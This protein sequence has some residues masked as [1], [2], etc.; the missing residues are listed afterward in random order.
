MTGER[1]GIREGRQYFSRLAIVTHPC[2]HLEDSSAQMRMLNIEERLHSSQFIRMLLQETRKPLSKLPTVALFPMAA[3]E[4]VAA[5]VL[6]VDRL[7]L[8][9]ERRF[10][11]LG[12]MGGESMLFLRLLARIQLFHEITVFPSFPVM[13]SCYKDLLHNA[14]VRPTIIREHLPP[15]LAHHLKLI[16]KT[17]FSKIARNKHRV[18]HLPAIPFKRVFKDFR[19]KIAPG[20][21]MAHMDIRHGGENQFRIS[22]GKHPGMSCKSL[23][24]GKACHAF[25]KRPTRNIIWLCF[26]R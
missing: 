6:H 22:T 3:D 24:S 18:N 7:V 15:R 12:I 21:G 14:A 9:P 4:P 17:M 20:F 25:Q 5:N 11:G 8:L 2:L 23:S 26:H 1:D 19:S 16:R 10:P 13:V